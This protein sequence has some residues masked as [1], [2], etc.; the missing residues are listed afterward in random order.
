[1]TTNQMKQRMHMH[2]D[3]HT[4]SALTKSTIDDMLHQSNAAKNTH[5]HVHICTSY[6]LTCSPINIVFVVDKKDSSNSVNRSLRAP[7][8]QRPM[9]EPSAELRVKH[10]I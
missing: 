9:N 6:T 3:V 2:T 7:L 4:D 10:A 1:M 8:A 5:I